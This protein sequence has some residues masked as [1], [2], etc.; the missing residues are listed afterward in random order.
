MVE[1][2]DPKQIGPREGLKVLNGEHIHHLALDQL[3]TIN[4]VL[5]NLSETKGLL[6][7]S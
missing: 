1:G 5:H 7:L 6:E 3:A 2:E 4:V